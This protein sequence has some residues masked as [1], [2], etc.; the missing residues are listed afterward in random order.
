MTEFDVLS[1]KF[2]PK[3]VI[4]NEK[5]IENIL[6]KF[7]IQKDQLPRILITD[8][9][10]K[11]IGGKVGDVIMIIRDSPT[12]GVSEFYRIVIEVV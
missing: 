12:A 11:R 8:P 4:L 6:K 7:K 2:V 9:V 3:H 10:I 5:E 1:H